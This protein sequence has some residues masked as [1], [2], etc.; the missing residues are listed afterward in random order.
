MSTDPNENVYAAPLADVTG[1]LAETPPEFSPEG[2]PH[3]LILAWIGVILGIGIIA[4]LFLIGLSFFPS[5][6]IVPFR[7]VWVIYTRRQMRLYESTW[8]P[9]VRTFVMGAW[10]VNIILLCLDAFV[11]LMI[12]VC[13][14]VLNP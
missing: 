9:G 12:A 4:T 10:I 14:A 6:M 5:L 7:L 2:F 13:F 8:Q 1:E 3:P 11:V